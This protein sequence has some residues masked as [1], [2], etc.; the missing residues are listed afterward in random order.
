M[1]DFTEI[2]EINDPPKVMIILSS[3]A[4]SDVET[5]V[6]ELLCQLSI[7]QKAQWFHDAMTI[8]RLPWTPILT[9][10]VRSQGLTTTDGPDDSLSPPPIYRRHVT[11]DLSSEILTTSELWTQ[12][13]EWLPDWVTSENPVCM[14]RAS[15]DG[16]K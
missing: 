8:Q 13:W 5:C 4:G 10:W 7:A 16:Y 12:V 1:C 3:T 11:P 15:R 14:F 6:Q 2:A 9:R